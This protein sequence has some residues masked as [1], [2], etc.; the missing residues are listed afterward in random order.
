MTAWRLSMERFKAWFVQDCLPL[1]AARAYDSA[2]GGFHESLDFNGAPA[3]DGV[4]RVRVQARQIYTFSMAA[5]AG[6]A[7]EGERLAALGFDD[8]L[9]KACPEAGARGCVHLLSDDGEVLDDRRDLY[10][11]AFLLL[12]CSARWKAAKDKRATELAWRAMDFLDREL[13][14][15][16]GG[17]LE[18]DR[19]E[20]PR[21][22]NPHM[23]LF[24]AFMALADATG[25]ARWLD[26]AAQVFD[27][28]SMRFLSRSDTLLEYFQDDLKT[29]DA[30][31][32]GVVEPGHMMEWIWLLGRY[33]RLQGANNRQLMKRLFESAKATGLDKQGFLV[34]A[35]DR[36][37]GAN[38][39]ARRLWPQTEY[40][41]AALT[42]SRLGEPREAEAGALIDRLFET[43]LAPPGN[44]HNQ[45]LWCDQY[46]GHGAPCVT[47][48]P[49]SILYHLFESVAE[50][51]ALLET[52]GET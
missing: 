27:L 24:E 36:S 44:G 52:N 1:W 17:W 45:G 50:T 31:K 15:P 49:A 19:G 38:A 5:L 46:D 16:H 39:G 37:G 51:A 29:Q 11:Q 33:D 12:A 42:L 18:N 32:G 43:Y 35:V 13:V 30:S 14:S 22:Q 28:F 23:H 41:K 34:D 4:R 9:D 20:T 10:D 21:R 7:P 25:E 40:L 26:R 6:W 3:G 2:R 48:V 47:D 8:F